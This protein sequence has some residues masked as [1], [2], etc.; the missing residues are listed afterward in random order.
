MITHF[1]VSFLTN[2]C[3]CIHS[4]ALCR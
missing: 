1:D 3:S 4:K 2:H